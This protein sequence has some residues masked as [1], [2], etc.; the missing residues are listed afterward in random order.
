MIPVLGG[1]G[2]IHFFDMNEE[3]LL[4]AQRTVISRASFSFKHGAFYEGKQDIESDCVDPHVGSA[5]FDELKILE[6]R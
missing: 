5:D 3:K 1:N 2:A 4:E 6:Y